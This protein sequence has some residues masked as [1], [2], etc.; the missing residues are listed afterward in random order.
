MSTTR[1]V[2]RAKPATP[3]A[4]HSRLFVDSIAKIACLI[5]D[6]GRIAANSSNASIADQ[7]PG[8]DSDTYVAGSNII[9]PS[10]QMQAQTRF[11][12]RIVASK[13]GAG[14]ATP[15]YRVRIGSAA[16]TA[17][18]ARATLTGPAQTA[19]ADNAVIEIIV[20][21]RSVSATGVLQA[22]VSMKHRQ[23][24]TGFATNATGSDDVTATGFDNTDLDGQYIGLSINGGASAAWTVTQVLAQAFW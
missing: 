2:N 8:F 3:P 11:I 10:F 14:V 23:A 15:I 18:T 17:D 12:W 1:Y 7:G 21:V 5:D 9:I 24:A 6:A 19:N 16:S 4:G 22:S 13:T 20:T